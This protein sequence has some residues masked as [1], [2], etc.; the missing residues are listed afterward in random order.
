[1]PFKDHGVFDLFKFESLDVKECTP[2][3]ISAMFYNHPHLPTQNNKTPI[4]KVY[5][6]KSNQLLMLSKGQK[7][8]KKKV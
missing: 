5:N 8:Y 1:M 3:I 2:H 7:I 4:I 6:A